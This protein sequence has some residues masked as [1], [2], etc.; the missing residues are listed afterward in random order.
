[1]AKDASIFISDRQF[2]PD[3]RK[4][5]LVVFLDEHLI[6]IKTGNSYHLAV[7]LNTITRIV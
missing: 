5:A 6:V 7:Q 1:M 2:Y 3:Y 4:N